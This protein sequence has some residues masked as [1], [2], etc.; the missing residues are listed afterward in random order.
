MLTSIS[1]SAATTN[2]TGLTIPWLPLRLNFLPEELARELNQNAFARPIAVQAR[3]TLEETRWLL[4]QADRTSTIFAVVGWVDFR[5]PDAR[6]TRRSAAV[7][8]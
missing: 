1:G 7:A 5:A 2:M 8:D 6:T 3:Q 4:E